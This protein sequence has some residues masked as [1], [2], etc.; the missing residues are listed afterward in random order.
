VFAALNQYE[1]TMHFNEQST[2]TLDGDRATGETYCIAHHVFRTDGER[3]IMIAYL[4]YLD[5][6]VKGPG[7]WRFGERRLYLEFSDT[8]TLA[9]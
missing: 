1:V 5:T 4:R 8:R 2:V 3:Q 7:G 9:G 6:F